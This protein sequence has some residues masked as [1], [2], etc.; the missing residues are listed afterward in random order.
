MFLQQPQ[1]CYFSTPVQV[2]PRFTTPSVSPQPPMV[3]QTLYISPSP[4]L[5]TPQHSTTSTSSVNSEP[6]TTPEVPPMFFTG[7]TFTLVPPPPQQAF[8]SSRPTLVQLEVPR[9]SE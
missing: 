5:L 4:L 3:E 9:L 2:S 8:T 1:Q 7:N 6:S